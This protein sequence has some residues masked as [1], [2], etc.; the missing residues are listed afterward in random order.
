MVVSKA[1]CRVAQK[2]RHPLTLK[3]ITSTIG[4]HGSVQTYSLVL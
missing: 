3:P 1:M 2:V 4:A